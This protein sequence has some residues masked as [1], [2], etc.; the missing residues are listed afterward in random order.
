[1]SVL[2]GRLLLTTEE[3]VRKGLPDLG[4]AFCPC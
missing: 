1:M 2:D 4:G 3:K